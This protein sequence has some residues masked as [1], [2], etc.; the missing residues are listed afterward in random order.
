MKNDRERYVKKLRQQTSCGQPDQNMRVEIRSLL[1][2]FPPVQRNYQRLNI[3][4]SAVSAMKQ[5]ARRAATC[6]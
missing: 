3:A 6:D 5:L 2:D 1:R 4:P